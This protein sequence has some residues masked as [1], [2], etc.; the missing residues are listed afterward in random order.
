MVARSVVRLCGW[1]KRQ[2]NERAPLKVIR[3]T[4]PACRRSAISSRPLRG[5]L[6]RHSASVKIW[7][8]AVPFA[9]KVWWSH[10][11]AG[12]TPGTQNRRLQRNP[13]ERDG[14]KNPYKPGIR[15]GKAVRL[16]PVRY[17]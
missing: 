9:E 12:D 6:V 13:T 5:G 7:R 1:R 8:T 14:T 2:A 11:R 15:E 16:N 10:F 17:S 4:S 3:R